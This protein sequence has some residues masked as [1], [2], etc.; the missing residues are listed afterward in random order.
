MDKT[1]TT[2]SVTDQST[3]NSSGPGVDPSRTQAGHDLRAPHGLGESHPIE[4]LMG[5]LGELHA[6]VD[7]PIGVGRSNAS[8]PNQMPGQPAYI[9]VP[10]A[11]VPPV[12]FTTQPVQP[13][14]NAV[15]QSFSTPTVPRENVANTDSSSSFLSKQTPTTPTNETRETPNKV[16]KSQAT[17]KSSK[18]EAPATTES[19]TDK[20][21]AATKVDQQAKDPVQALERALDSVLK[22]YSSP[23]TQ[24]PLTQPVARSQDS[25]QTVQAHQ[26]SERPA[27]SEP[28]EQ[29]QPHISVDKTAS[30]Q[31]ERSTT[32]E[33]HP[34]S[35]Q[36]RP[37]SEAIQ[38]AQKA[39]VPN[40]AQSPSTQTSQ[41][42]EQHQ[43]R[44]QETQLDHVQQ[45]HTEQ[46]QIIQQILL[47][48]ID[49]FIP[50]Q[51]QSPIDQ[52]QPTLH[53]RHEST[54]VA[55]ETI[56]ESVI[57]KLTAIQSQLET[58]VTER[59][60]IEPLTVEANTRIQGRGDLLTQDPIRHDVK[61]SLDVRYNDRASEPSPLAR[62]VRE[63]APALAQSIAPAAMASAQ[64]ATPT[65]ILGS[66]SSLD[67][68]SE[69][70]NLLKRFSERS[71]NS[72]L[73][74]RLNSPL[75]KA[76][77]SIV[78]GAALGV[79]GVE[80]LI[81]AANLAL[82]ELLRALREE[83]KNSDLSEEERAL[84]EE[85]TPDLEAHI[86]N[87][88]I[89]PIQAGLVADVSGTIIDNGTNQ[90]LHGVLIGS[91]ELGSTI[92]NHQGRFIF[93][94]VP[95]GSPYTLTLYKLF[96]KLTPDT[97]SG[98]CSPASHHQILVQLTPLAR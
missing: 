80:L 57:D 43:Q 74:Q 93:K 23:T 18:T 30:P 79:V 14:V 60:R 56:R 11:Q 44:V 86:H 58:S 45:H 81:R 88:F 53:P 10:N 70:F 87:A 97:I 71:N 35:P 46:L 61:H 65:S 72:S 7:Q 37:E 77:L 19:V 92:S 21:T 64:G 24:E 83:K 33:Q 63:L 59:K 42:A 9:A 12:S 52:L 22:G 68:L 95:L 3:S 82:A 27:S 8:M 26:S 40:A 54:T 29:V 25:P 66:R 13:H 78:T 89:E 41:Q 39:E 17:E 50:T 48:Q 36:Q 67:T 73:L 28:R 32:P 31:S 6:L 38:L 51:P 15:A 98:I 94:N 84:I 2:N 76:C 75:D 4:K 55:V 34:S 5:M 47:T 49:Q 1:S 85:V 96:Y 16:E 62:L 69:L 91:A 90:P 20:S